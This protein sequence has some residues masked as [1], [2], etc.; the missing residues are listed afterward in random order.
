[1][2]IYDQ[3]TGAA[4]NYQDFRKR[5][6]FTPQLYGI[7][8]NIGDAASQF[9]SPRGRQAAMNMVEVGDML[10]PVGDTLDAM[11]MAGEGDYVGAMVNVAGVAIP[12][13]IV[14]LYGPQ[15]AL[16][17][18]KAIQ[19][20]LTGTGDSMAQVGADVYEKFIERMNQPGPGPE[21]VGS[22]LGNIAEM[23][24]QRNIERFGYD[25][26]DTAAP[27][28]NSAISEY[29]SVVNPGGK[30]IP[31]E[32]R[33]NLRRGD[34]YG[35]LPRGS[36]VIGEKGD[37]SF[38]RGSDGNFYATAYNPDVGE[39]DVV[40][41]IQGTGE[42]TEL[43]VIE[44]MQG[45]G[46][47]GELQY[48]F[49]SENPNAPTGGLTE[50][51]QRLLE[52]TY[53][54]MQD[55]GILPSIEQSQLGDNGG[56]SMLNVS[57]DVST[58]NMPEGSLPQYTGAAPN[59]T[60]PYQR[61]R[62]KNTTDRMQ[63]LEASV[64]DPDN[65]INQVFDNYIE[66]GKDLAGPDWYNTEELRDW[67][68]ST[69]GE[70]EGD[71]QWR[72]Y[73]ELIGTTSTGAKVPQNIRMASF[74]RALSPKDR[75]A[76]AQIV[77]DEGITP[78]AAAARLGVTPENTPD[79]YAYGHLK[80][81]NQAGNVVN[82]EAGTWDRAVPEDLTGAALSKYLQANPKVKGFGNDLLGDDTNIAAD[83]HFMRMLAMADG[84]GDFLNAQAKLSGENAEIAAQVIG[85]KRIKKYTNTRKVNGKPVS[86]INLF[87]AWQDGHIKDTS[88]FQ[89][90]PTAWADTPKANEYAA[91]EDMANRV[92]ETYGMTPAQFQASLWMGA[93]DMT[94]LA[95]ESQG[96]FMNLFRRS[97]DKRAEERGL[98]R[99]EMLLDFLYNK[100]PLAVGGAGVL[101]GLQMQNQ[102]D[103]RGI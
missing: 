98:S 82:R 35:M 101:G 96:T 49:R 89:Q 69:L 47:G 90:M 13:G 70:K 14:K 17:A 71:A 66:K 30:Q 43:A 1:M 19:E 21:V 45:Q 103:D 65:P 77:K 2:S 64:A 93:G 92:A 102:Q 58:V 25:P 11:Q 44:E 28:E 53:N 22:N 40:G 15:T 55:D 50:G 99:E 3:L 80:Q 10:N 88:A 27:V 18:A 59:R 34:M 38:H 56:P 60:E 61:Y 9:L 33:P 73:M 72:E 52:K 62:P 16:A 85:P 42:G 84:G 83:M 39:Q 29:L 36:E 86:E 48:L 6:G 46:I 91:Y 78:K 12:A 20:T 57:G 68:V 97:L 32:A 100:S 51:G 8:E 7:L 94:G 87:K 54:R 23:R 41:Y 81:R 67:F 76:V 95:D 63:R 31:D 79:N 75:A 74:Y 37:I 26:A 24:R 5:G 4:Q